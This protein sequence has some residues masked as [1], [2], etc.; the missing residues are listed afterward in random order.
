MK[1]A[2]VLFAASLLAAPSHAGDWGR[3][4][5]VGAELFG[6]DQAH[7]SVG[8]TIG[9]MGLT[10][11]R[12]TFRSYSA[13]ILYDE[14]DPSRSSATVV[15]DAASIDTDMDVRDK[16]LRGP[17]F[18]DVEKYP[19]IVFQSRSIEKAG[20]DRYIVHGT[21]EM[22]GV[23]HEV[24]IPMTQT[25]ARMPDSGWGNMRIGGAGGV[26]VKRTDFGILGGEFWGAK[27]LSDDVEIEIAILGNRYNFDRWSF[28]SREKPSI[29]EVLARTVDSAGAEAAVGR[30]R[31]LKE[32][33]PGDYNFAVDQIT[34]AANRLLQHRRFPEALALFRLAA[35]ESPKE[36]VV[37]ARI[38]EI[39]AAMGNRDAA[40]AAYR[41]ALEL[42]PQNPEAIEM[43]QRLE[44]R[45]S[46]R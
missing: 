6:M 7:S 40:L 28:D 33:N 14:K 12:G 46:A 20:K 10:R 21:L 22:H 30:Y 17:R 36:T 4:E 13:A 9:F 1:T 42:A 26:K 15:I 44:S 32:K 43:V 31:E 34:L 23:T 5:L 45:V 24:A 2:A 8:F 18:F 3:V 39:H 38:G 19:R 37:Q 25:V 29:G 27:A 41:K 11:V 35:E 16:D